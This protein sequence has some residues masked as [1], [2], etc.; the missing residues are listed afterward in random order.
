LGV[1]TDVILNPSF[2][3]T[4]FER[5]KK[6]QISRIQKEK[7]SPNGIALR[8]L[9]KLLFGEKHPYGNP[10][11]GAGFETTVDKI[12]RDQVVKF[13][14]TWIKPNNAT[15]VVVGDITVDEIKAKLENQFKN[16]KSGDVPKKNIPT[17]DIPSK[18]VIYLMDKPGSIQSVVI[19]GVLS[20]PYGK[21]NEVALDVM[22]AII[23]GEFTSRINM[24]I[25]EDKH[26]S[27]GASSFIL[28]NEGQRPYLA[29]TSVQSDKTKETVQEIYKEFNQYISSKPATNEEVAKN[30]NN[31]LLQVP[32]SYE[33][34]DAVANDMIQII[35]YNLKD[36]FK[37]QEI[38]KLKNLQVKDIQAV[39]KETIKL[40][41]F[42]WVIVGDK[43][44]V[45]GPLKE[46]GYTIKYI[47]ADGNLLK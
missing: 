18:P 34:M 32:G 2:P 8:I 40:E 14:Q 4:D 23:G 5:V 21:V 46:I 19:G 44:K 22:N 25:R 36:D 37:K 33:T 11:S 12:T 43:A 20:N 7:V 10:Y 42:T 16:W 26:W 38:E 17:A 24:N 45:E 27:Y 9:P 41:Q 13:H 6:I 3:Q 47:D 39:A 29:F 1:F 15:L 28:S 30:Q 31:K 35:K